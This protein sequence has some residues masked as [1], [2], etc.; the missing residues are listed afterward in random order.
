MAKI[1]QSVPVFCCRFVLS[2][3]LFHGMVRSSI[4]RVCFYFFSKVR[5]FELFYLPQKGSERNSESC[6]Y[7]CSTDGNQ[8][9]FSSAEGL[10]Q[11]SESFLFRGKAGIPSEIPICSVYS[12]F[13]IIIFCRKFPT[14]L[15][16]CKKLRDVNG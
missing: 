12:V 10:E 13:C 11:N 16:H 3:F 9:F 7:F 14:I 15:G 5:Y 8:V 1:R 4:R 2:C 6:S